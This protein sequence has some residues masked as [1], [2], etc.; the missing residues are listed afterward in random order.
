MAMSRS[1]A[2]ICCTGLPSIRMSPSS[3]VSSACDGAQC[4]RLAAA[5]LVQAAR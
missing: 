1:D 5:R 4:R 2:L 3:I